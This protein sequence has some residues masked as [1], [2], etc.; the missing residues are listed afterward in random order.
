M[1]DVESTGLA[2]VTSAVNGL[3]APVKTSFFKALSDLLGGLT[4]IPAAKLKQYA[5]GIEDTTAARSTIAAIIAKDAAEGGLADPLLRQA[6]AEIYFPTA[7]RK[8]RNRIGVAQKA[9]HHIASEAGEHPDAAPPEDDW[10]NFYARFAEDASSEKL[11]DL[12]GRILAGQIV[13]PGSFSQST[14]RA[15]VE[16]DQATATDFSLVWAKSVGEAVDYSAEF[17]RGE[18]FA[19]WQRL[20]EAGLMASRDTVQF[21]PPFHPIINGNGLWT[22]FSVDG[23]FLAVQFPEHCSARWG[24]ID[25]TR[26]GR[27]L[28]RIITRPDY[29]ANMREAGQKLARQG[30]TRVEL[31][32]S[33]NPIEIIFPLL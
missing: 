32:S 8:A 14:I 12:F 7:L 19:R 5:Q 28:G 4:A 17:Q 30:V 6:A 2:I 3:A 10:M 13:R 29:E 20:A 16:L 26:I 27:E 21:L 23:I 18:W 1:S 15:V 33:G 22:P 25:F 9:A 31:H 11:Q 24:H